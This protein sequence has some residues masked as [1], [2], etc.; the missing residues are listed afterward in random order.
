MLGT[1]ISHYRVLSE[2]GAGG[3]GV[4]YLAEDERLNRKVALKFIAPSV[5]ED[6]VARTRLLR[7]A[8]AASTLDHP[9]IA[10]VYEVGD[11][12]GHL[13]I[14]M[15]YYP[16]E[17]LRARIERG[18]LPVAD[19][20]ATLE[21]IAEGLAAAHAAGIVHRDLKPAN[22]ILTR[23]GQVKILD[24]GLAK[25]VA[26]T[27]ETTTE[28]TE[29][30]TTLGTAAYMSPEQARG[31]HVDQRTDMWAFGVLAFEMLAGKRPFNGQTTTA[32]QSSLLT[33]RPPKL[34][35]LRHDA[36]AEVESL[37]E[38]ALVKSA[39]DRTLTAEAS[40]AAL[41]RSRA[42]VA[43]HHV[44]R[45]GALLRRPATALPILAAVV[46]IA[47]AIAWW[48]RGAMNRRWAKYT[49]EPEIS[50]LADRQEFIAAADLASTAERYLPGDPDL[51]HLWT[52]IARPLTVNSEPAGAEVSFSAY[53]Q[54]E[55]WHRVGVTPL[56]AARLPLGLIRVKLEKAGFL[57]SE[58]IVLPPGPVTLSL[59]LPANEQVPTGMVRTSGS[60]AFSIY[61]FGLE[62]PR[63]RINPFWIDRNEVTNRQYK[64]FVD[65]GG[66]Q[67]QEFWKL[68]FLKDGRTI[69][70]AEA[71][72]A[73]RDA[74]GRAGPAKW[75]LGSYLAGQDDFPVGGVSWYE[76]NA[77][78]EF[79]GK[80]LP[81]VFHWNWVAAQALTGFVI[82]LANFN[83][84]APVAVGTTHALHRFGAY[85]LAGNV[86]EW[87]VNEAPAGKR[88]ILGGGWD[89]PP[90]LFRDADARSP[91]DRAPNFGFRTVKYDAGDATVAAV[92][93]IVLPPSRNYSSEKPVGDVVFEAY[94]RLY[95][96]DRTDVKDS[97]V[98]ID[99][100]NPDWKLEKVS[101]PAAYGQERVIA[102]V[103]LPKV[104]TGPFQTVVYMPPAPAWVLRS[105]AG[106]LANPPFAFVVK[107]G[108]TVVLPIYKGTFERASDE[109]RV[110]LPKDTNLWRDYIIDFSKDLGRTLDYL[111]T[112]SEVDRDRLA[113]LG[114]SRGA[115][116]APMLLANEPRIKTAVLWIPGFYLEKQTPEA[117]AINFAPR[118]KIP[119][120]QLSGRYD[121]NFPDETS[122]APFFAMLGTPADQKRRIVY[123]TGHNL[124]TNEA[125]KE[126]LDWLDRYLGPVAR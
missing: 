88:Y 124:P 62:T 69:P 66:Y 11:F 64:A 101:F 44:S 18:P 52:T 20:A 81:T 110:D 120:L 113:F 96:Y 63:M 117:D 60:S 94:R 56:K 39:G 107:S 12:N 97:V 71:I 49:A 38:R 112:R 43:D 53:G 72:A 3:M 27:A 16:G 8:Q 83:S 34:R 9:N 5:V 68:P 28:V 22:V 75:E 45:V 24:F 50:R 47:V 86:K 111:S 106:F 104:S 79:A 125:V 91:F 76:A 55:S 122:S 93:G 25:L 1:L 115:S 95:S 84:H 118:V 121:Y 59:T 29:A 82:P 87:C 80:S 123:D 105:S 119:I 77:Y 70:W 35:T 90:Y 74:T 42:K 78:A 30:G 26:P 46:A 61:V 6:S 92:S 21:Q 40:A 51:A 58:D 67:R 19:A 54:P 99:E 41:A 4:V 85:D 36:P 31:E 48:G 103:F 109:Y 14:A 114:F 116:L 10:T 89:E 108:R 126:T 17:T 23:S 15:A 102:Y 65:A 2:L 32:I 13:F 37:V 100:T 57:T 33:D 98:S 7:E 73:F